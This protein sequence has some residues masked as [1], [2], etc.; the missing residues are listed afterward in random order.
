M[1]VMT[2]SNTLECDYLVVGAGATG[3]AFADTLLHEWRE[4]PAP[5]VLLVDKH[6]APGGQW[7]DSYSFVRLH[8]PSAMYG[9][10][11][12]PLEPSSTAGGDAGKDEVDD[13]K[14]STTSL[15]TSPTKHRA[16]REEILRYYKRVVDKLSDKFSLQFLGGYE[17]I[18]PTSSSARQVD[19]VDMQGGTCLHTLVRRGHVEPASADPSCASPEGHAQSVRVLRKVVDARYLEPD[20]PIFVAPKFKFA[21]E[22]VKLI[23]PNDLATPT[24]SAGFHTAE[25]EGDST[26]DD[27]VAAG[28]LNSTTGT[29]PR[30]T[31]FVIIGAGKTG[32]DSVVYLQETLQVRPEDIAWVMPSDMWITAR[33]N[34]GSCM[35]LLAT[36]V[37]AAKEDA[38]DRSSDYLPEKDTNK[39]SLNY[40]EFIQNGFLEFEKQEKVYRMF[41]NKG[42]EMD[43]ADSARIAIPTKF[44]DATLCRRE[45]EILRRV[46]QVYRGHR[47]TE[48]SWNTA[49]SAYALHF[50]DA[51]ISKLPWTGQNKSNV[52]FIH[53]SAGAFN[54]TKQQNAVV[55]ASSKD[56]DDDQQGKIFSKDKIKIQDV[57]GTP[58]F[59][60]VGSVI[61]KLETL[62]SS[63]SS[64]GETLFTNE[65]KNAMCRAPTPPAP[66]A[67]QE[68]KDKS[69]SDALTASTTSTST[70]EN[71]QGPAEQDRLAPSDDSGGVAGMY[72]GLVQRISNLRDWYNIADLGSW[73]HGD[74]RRKPHR[75]FNLNHLPEETAKKLVERTYEWISAHAVDALAC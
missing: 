62:Q 58:G 72:G 46:R 36:C 8:Q 28:N 35:E 6:A 64:S 31:K 23:T 63:A 56:N 54:Y 3:L 69:S 59:C 39:K 26:W 48:I 15:K 71:K 44:K 19:D 57:Y 67:R 66:I 25:N 37:D 49:D 40:L 52:L 47:V 42:M 29:T 21:R 50:A 1:T 14:A 33:E 16:T 32:M 74:G 68:N 75:L 11:S 38:T 22:H 7:N 45:L 41:S 30:A 17:Y 60:F 34:I 9:V 5:R 55:E 27:V 13:T 53:C 73:L 43:T 10:E 2:T 24:S 65:M 4:G 51:S 70:N 12:E 61:A 20:L 18:F